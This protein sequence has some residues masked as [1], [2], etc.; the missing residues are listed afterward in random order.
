MNNGELLQGELIQVQGQQL[1]TFLIGD[2]AYPLLPWLVKP[3]Q[4][5]SSLTPQQKNF[6]YRLSRARVVVEIAFG[7]LKARWRRL[8]KQ[9]EMDIKNVPHVIAAC[10]VLHNLCEIHGDSFN[11]EWLQE[12]DLMDQPESD[13][14]SQL[15]SRTGNDLRAILMN[16]FDQN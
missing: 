7:R 14:T 5:S 13:A 15:P 3:F 8:S 16:Y 12:V 6:N 10:C 11:E 1:R 2:S 9:I 4:F